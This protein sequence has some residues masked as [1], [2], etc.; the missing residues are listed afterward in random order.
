MDDVTSTIPGAYVLFT[1]VSTG[2]VTLGTFGF[3]G[4]EPLP[5]LRGV[6]AA[7]LASIITFGVAWF[8]RRSR[9]RW[10]R[11]DKIGLVVSGLVPASM[12]VAPPVQDFVLS[13]PLIGYVV[14]IPAIAGYVVSVER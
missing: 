3:T 8:A 10:D 6:N 14:A 7:M 1:L 9:K 13:N 12:I 2:A 4:S 11:F 5:V